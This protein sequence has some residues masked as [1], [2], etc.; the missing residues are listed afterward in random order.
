MNLATSSSTLQSNASLCLSTTSSLAE[1][2]LYTYGK[3]KL[4]RASSKPTIRSLN[5]T[6]STTLAVTSIES[7]PKDDVKVQREYVNDLYT[8]CAQA[9][10]SECITAE[11]QKTPSLL[12]HSSLLFRQATR[13]G[14]Q[15]CRVW[16]WFCI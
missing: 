5:A 3:H 11:L 6:L 14:H 8:N 9:I 4:Y 13:H 1:C 2:N 12:S 10:C 15:S 16:K 7:V